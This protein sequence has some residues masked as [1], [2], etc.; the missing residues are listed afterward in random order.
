M[1][2]WNY[3]KCI[4]R[5]LKR[6]L[7]LCAMLA[8]SF[9]QAAAAVFP[10]RAYQSAWCNRHGGVM[11][12][13]MFDRTRLD[14]LLPEYAVEVDFAHKWAEAIGQAMHYARL[15]GKPPG[16]LLIIESPDDEKHLMRLRETAYWIRVWTIRP[17]DIR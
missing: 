1:A 7:G 14:C 12:V 8:F 3:L 6:P 5:R 4:S 11:E 9:T 16:I 15:T 10:E 2:L 13:V 17:E